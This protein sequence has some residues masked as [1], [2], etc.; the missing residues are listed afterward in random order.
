VKFCDAFIFLIYQ[1]Y[2]NNIIIAH[3]HVNVLSICSDVML[4]VNNAIAGDTGA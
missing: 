1:S 4:I 3:I 2:N